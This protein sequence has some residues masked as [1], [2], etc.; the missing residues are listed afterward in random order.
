MPRA[1][2]IIDGDTTGLRRAM[3]EIPGITVRAQSVMTAQARR[4]GSERVAIDRTFER[5][6]EAISTRL[7]RAKEKAAR[8]TAAKER[9]EARSVAQADAQS[10]RARESIAAQLARAKERAAR[11]ATA[12]EA[13]EGRRRVRNDAQFAREHDQIHTRL[14]AAR[15]AR[16]RQ[17]QRQA[18][19]LTRERRG[20]GREMGGRA[21]AVVG[22][23]AT[24]VQGRTQAARQTVADRTSALNTSLVQRGTSREEN[25]ADNAR[26]QARLR[27]VRTGVAPDVAIQ[28]IA[29]AQSFANTLGGD[30]ATQRRRNVDSTLS[31]VEFAGT[32]DPTNVSGIVNMGAILRRRVAD[33]QLQRRILR[34][35]VGTSFEGSVETDQ[36]VT[37]GLPGL[38]QA[39]SAGTANAA[40]A[41]R[42]RVTAEIAQDFFAQLQAQ[43]A[44]G[45]T[46]GVAA[47]RT[48]T[49]RNALS[50][51]PRQNRLGLALAE[52]ARTGT[53]EQQAAFAAAFTKDAQTGQYTMNT[54]VRDTPSNAARLFGTM[55][56]NDEGALRNAMGANGL[57]GPRQLMNIPDVAAIGSYFGMTTGSDG[58]QIREYDHVAQLARASLTPEQEATMAATRA[59]EDRTRLLREQEGA[60]GNARR[61]G[62]LTRA[63]DAI[64]SFTT[65]NP[66]TS[67]LGTG[68]LAT[69]ATAAAKYLG[70]AA[71]ATL[72]GPAAALVGASAGIG[73]ALGLYGSNVTA[74]TGRDANGREV[75]TGE[76]LARGAAAVTSGAFFSFGPIITAIQDL[77]RLLADALRSTPL[78]A[79]IDPHDAAQVKSGALPG[80]R[81]AGET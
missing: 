26:I 48:N 60:T 72:G 7:M 6:H 28:A 69:G 46:V 21:A 76:R 50:N 79:T 70:G 13:A 68:L 4:G 27:E 41:D 47:N 81:T 12:A 38:L 37:S 8:D 66:T 16:E 43:A 32:V 61:P 2:L 52:T 40:P 42:D 15:V 62:L 53:P 74:G 45:R 36:M 44:G 75:S 49:V 9:A 65:A 31:D 18:D 19:Q 34:G 80:R 14:V 77:P 63:S 1:T 22:Q 58:S 35:A 30:T 17:A 64:T 23:V 67:M 55:F 25:D 57:G 33:P 71:L 20:Q 73:S 24:D 3:G 78:T 59:Q 39:I 56:N 5:E 51:L 29:G 54:D 11:E 10:A